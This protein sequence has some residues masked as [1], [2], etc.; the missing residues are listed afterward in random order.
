MIIHTSNKWKDFWFRCHPDQNLVLLSDW[1]N[2]WLTHSI[3][4]EQCNMPIT[5]HDLWTFLRHTLLCVENTAHLHTGTDYL[6]C[7][8]CLAPWSAQLSSN[9]GAIGSH[10]FLLATSIGIHKFLLATNIGKDM[11]IIY[12][13]KVASIWFALQGWEGGQ[14]LIHT[15]GPRRWPGSYSHCSANQMLAT[16]SG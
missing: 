6:K 4:N 11:V 12:P 7:P 2:S 1:H 9:S 13:E 14:D 15:A 3:V 8:S 10:K 5:E 16:F